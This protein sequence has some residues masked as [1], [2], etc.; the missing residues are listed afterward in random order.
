MAKNF[1][2][3]GFV[4]IAIVYPSTELSAIN[5]K[6]VNGE[7]TED[8]E[9]GTITFHQDWKGCYVVKVNATIVFKEAIYT[10]YADIHQHEDHYRWEGEI[11]AAVE[12]K[13]EAKV[14]V[15]GAR[16]GAGLGKIGGGGKV[17]Y[18]NQNKK[19]VRV[20]KREGHRDRGLTSE[21]S[22]EAGVPEI[23]KIECTPV[24][25][26]NDLNLRFD[27]RYDGNC[28]YQINITLP[29]N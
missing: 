6:L 13:A 10:E 28:Q 29:K 4:T 8:R 23:G 1:H 20:K 3:A 12:P 19:V 16:L 7:V 9:S 5:T 14:G 24:W 17:V 2:P 15:E 22:F 25:K 21:L 18:D 11:G 26:R 27:Q